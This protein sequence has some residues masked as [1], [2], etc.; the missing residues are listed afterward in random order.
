MKA[1]VNELDL[2]DDLT[3]RAGNSTFIRLSSAIMDNI[4]NEYKNY[5]TVFQSAFLIPPLSKFELIKT[6]SE[7][8]RIL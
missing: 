1:L 8:T 7:L 3:D 2:T 4:F 6:K 5:V